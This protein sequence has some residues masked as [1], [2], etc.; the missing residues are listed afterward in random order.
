MGCGV[1]GRKNI[2]KE[3][4]PSKLRNVLKII[5]NDLIENP[6]KVI[7]KNWILVEG[8]NRYQKVMRATRPYQLWTGDWKEFVSILPSVHYIYQNF[9]SLSCHLLLQHTLS[10]NQFHH[11][12]VS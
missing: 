7:R 1:S 9:L 8:K 3:S 11:L 6:E 2:K 10:L 4:K 12:Y 5:K